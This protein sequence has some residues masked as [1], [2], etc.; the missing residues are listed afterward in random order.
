MV[1]HN[2]RQKLATAKP[3]K[4]IP[5]EVSEAAKS[6]AADFWKRWHHMRRMLAELGLEGMRELMTETLRLSPE[7]LRGAPEEIL[8]AVRELARCAAAL[9]CME[10]SGVAEIKMKGEK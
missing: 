2:R 5:P 10:V 1:D 8:L 7:D 6:V 9:A 3:P 4:P